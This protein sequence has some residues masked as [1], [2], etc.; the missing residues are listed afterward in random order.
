MCMSQ[1]LKMVL[2]RYS[3]SFAVGQAAAWVHQAHSGKFRRH[4]CWSRLLCR[5]S[6][7]LQ[8]V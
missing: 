6:T 8:G 2:F 5:V 7:S 1:V 4:V 3:K